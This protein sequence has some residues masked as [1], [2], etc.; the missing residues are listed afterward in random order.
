MTYE[1]PKVSERLPIEGLLNQIPRGSD[2]Y[3][4]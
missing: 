1:A 2:E 4:P 3:I